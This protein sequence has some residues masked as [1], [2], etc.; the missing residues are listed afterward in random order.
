MSVGDAVGERPERQGAVIRPRQA[1]APGGR[2]SPACQGTSSSR[3][4]GCVATAAIDFPVLARRAIDPPFSG[5]GLYYQ[6][7]SGGTRP[8]GGESSSCSFIG[9]RQS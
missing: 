3:W 7:H 6:V 9:P 2:F 1:L 5:P 8:V 4:T